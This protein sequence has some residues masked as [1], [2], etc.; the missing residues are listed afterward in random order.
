MCLLYMYTHTHT[1]THTHTRTHTHILASLL[2][3]S[4][5]DVLVKTLTPVFYVHFM[6][7]EMD[8][9]TV[10]LALQVIVAPTVSY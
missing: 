1:H 5:A 2:Q 9:R 7:P 8:A 6:G 10:I 4:I 3:V